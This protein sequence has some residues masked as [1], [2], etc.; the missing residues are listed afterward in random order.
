MPFGKSSRRQPRNNWAARTGKP[1]RFTEAPSAKRVLP[2]TGR[3]L[4]SEV[5]ASA[6]PST[7]LGALTHSTLLRVIL[8]LPA[9]SQTLSLPA[10][11]LSNPSNGSLS[12][13]SKR[14]RPYIRHSG[15]WY[16]SQSVAYRHSPPYRRCRVH[17]KLRNSF[18]KQGRRTA[19]MRT[20]PS[21]RPFDKLIRSAG[22]G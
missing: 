19:G 5:A 4:G 6:S 14:R 21:A 13:P 1:I 22:S 9:V 3:N 10:V 15:R 17:P 11:S 2:R 20:R 7:L 12:N 18:P 16:H 8:S